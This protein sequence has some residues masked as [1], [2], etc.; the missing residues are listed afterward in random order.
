M[1]GLLLERLSFDGNEYTEELQ[2]PYQRFS[3][4][5][6]A[7][8]LLERYL[9]TTSEATI[10]R[11]F[12]V[13]RPLGRIFEVHWGHTFAQPGLAEAIMVEFPERVKRVHCPTTRA[14]SCSV[15][16]RNVG[17]RTAQR[18]CFWRACTGDPPT[19]SHLVQTASCRCT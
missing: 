9:N 19:R 18:R 12:Y 4:H 14:S 6:I 17:W 2:L 10:R 15:C 8:H 11:S 16:Q 13:N 1:E 5:L 7:R 3:D